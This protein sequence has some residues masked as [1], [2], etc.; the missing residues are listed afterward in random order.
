M[1][2]LVDLVVDAAELAPPR[3]RER[4]LA[5]GASSL[6]AAD[7]VAVLLGSGT[8]GCPAETLAREVLARAG[9]LRGLAGSTA[10]ELAA[11]SG[12][13]DARA[14]RLLA[15]LELGRRAASEPL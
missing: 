7:L 10:I 14:A 1:T 12:V 8:V 5:E 4:L 2:D 3:P 13:G 6:D 15:A 9:G 11:M